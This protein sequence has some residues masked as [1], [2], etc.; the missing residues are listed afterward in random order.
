MKE[1]RSVTSLSRLT[2]LTRFFQPRSLIAFTLFRVA[3]GVVWLVDGSMKFLLCQPSDVIKLIQDASQGQPGWLHPWYNFWLA[4]LTS[5]PAT[6][7]HGIGSIE[8]ALGSALVI[9]FL[10]KSVYLGG[11]ILSLMIWSIVEG[12][13]GPY[14][15]GST[16]TDIG[17]AIMY[18]FIFVAIIIVE[19][20]S[21]YSR[22]S[23]D[24]L[25][26]RKLNGWKHIEEFYDEK[27][28]SSKLN[29]F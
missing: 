23:L 6:C 28:S 7:L 14:K 9:G 13:G 3:F 24:A 22:H 17:A 1:N 8:L 15:S 4:S 18:A 19:R 27:K 21:N 5:A 2:T 11:I 12:F 20:S 16:S 10:R 29:G 26:E 25:I